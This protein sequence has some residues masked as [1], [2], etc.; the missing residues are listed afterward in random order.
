M[1]I[2]NFRKKSGMKAICFLLNACMFLG[3]GYAQNNELKT[4]KDNNTLLWE[5]SGNGLVRPSYLFGTFHL[6]C[7]EDI[8]FSSNLKQA[9]TQTDEVYLELDM[10]DPA[11]LFG[12]MALLNMKDNKTLK[13]L[14]SAE[15][16]KKVSGFLKD[17]L[18]LFPV[19]FQRMKPELLAALFYPKMLTCS[20]T[21]SLEDA[22]MGIAKQ[23]GKEIRGLETMAQQA[24]VFDSIPY[25]KQAAELLKVIDSI[26]IAKQEF[27]L[28][29]TA[30]REQ[31]LDEIEKQ[32]TSPGATM[33]ENMGIL[34]YDR[35]RNWVSQLKKIMKANAVFVAVGAG[36]LVGEQG[37]IALLR[38]A[39]F[40]LR[41]VEN[42]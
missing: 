5:I 39:G 33:A 37:L 7:R 41:P 12:A 25:E 19:M 35:N 42:K 27:N 34:L 26:D 24:A 31:K 18:K 3:S 15:D 29:I 11:T 6:V 10:D 32:V 20:G 13:D 30:Y 17:S 22:V 16:Y 2:L 23:Q 36:H 40:T 21:V 14:Y 8:N 38:A 28:L 9:L 4:N 1:L